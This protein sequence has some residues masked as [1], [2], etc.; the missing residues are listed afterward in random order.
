MR[1]AVFQGQAD[2]SLGVFH[3]VTPL[4]PALHLGRTFSSFLSTFSFFLEAFTLVCFVQHMSHFDF[5]SFPAGFMLRSA[6]FILPWI[7]NGSIST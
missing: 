2:R 4:C 1:H 6:S 5:I 7:E 3:C